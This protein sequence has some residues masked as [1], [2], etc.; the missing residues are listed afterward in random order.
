MTRRRERIPAST[1]GFSLVE[2]LA[3]TVLMAVVMA[4]LATVTAQWLPSG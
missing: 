4:A 2:I 3:A 1:R